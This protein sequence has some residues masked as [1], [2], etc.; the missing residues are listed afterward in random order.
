[1]EKPNKPWGTIYLDMDGVLA[2][3]SAYAA[4]VL[5][6]SIDTYEAKHGSF[7]MWEALYLNAPDFF[8]ILPRYPYVYEL[9]ALCHSC[10][11]N[12]IVLSSPSRVNTPLCIAQKRVWLD[13]VF[14]KRLPAIF[15]RDKAKFAGPGRLLIDDYQKK[16]DAWKNAGGDAFLFTDFEK[17]RDFL[18]A[19][20]RSE[21]QI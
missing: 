21:N 19:R 15:E 14:D 13:R 9:L 6:E 12:V 4:S 5:G 17:C 16:T 2:N 8:E 11:D 1:M 18:T 20:L 10:A 3:L 7:R